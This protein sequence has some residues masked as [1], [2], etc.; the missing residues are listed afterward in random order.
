MSAITEQANAKLI[1]GE[2]GLPQ[3]H[4]SLENA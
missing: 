3:G 4:A 1:L 2:T